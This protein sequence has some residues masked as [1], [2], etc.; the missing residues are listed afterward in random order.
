MTHQRFATLA[1]SGG[2]PSEETLLD[3]L[4]QAGP[5]LRDL[6]WRGRSSTGLGCSLAGPRV[7]GS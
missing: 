2:A 4:L 5:L 3:A 1:L 6:A 7:R